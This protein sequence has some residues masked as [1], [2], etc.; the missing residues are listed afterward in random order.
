MQEEDNILGKE[1]G[2][3]GGCPLVLEEDLCVLPVREKVGPLVQE[4]KT[5]SC[6][7]TTTYECILHKYICVSL[8]ARSRE[9]S[10]CVSSAR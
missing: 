6:E 2:Q 3:G 1:D 7:N 5:S 8:T 10:H 4:D 9:R